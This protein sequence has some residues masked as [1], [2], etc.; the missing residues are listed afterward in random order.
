[1]TE[2]VSTT[3]KT[4]RKELALLL[5][6]LLFGL[7]LLPI[8]VFFVGN[9]VFGDYGASGFSGFFNALSGKIRGGEWDAWFLILSPYLAWQTVRLTAFLWR[10]LGAQQRTATSPSKQRM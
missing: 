8:A 10:R 9:L 1:M 7:I 3:G 5:G 2:S 4:V 6:L